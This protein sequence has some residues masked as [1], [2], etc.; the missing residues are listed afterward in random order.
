[1]NVFLL[2]DLEGIPDVLS[3]NAVSRSGST[4]Q[5]A[6]HSLT[7]CV[8][9]AAAWCREAGA[10]R[11][12]FLDGHGGGGNIIHDQ[13]DTFAEQV[14][15]SE[16]QHLLKEGKIDCQIELGAHARAGTIGG[17]L[18]HT[19]NSSQWFSYRING[20]EYSE[21][22]IHAVI[23]GRYHV[24]VVCCIGDEAACQQ[25]K[26]YIPNIVTA[27]VKRALCRNEALA[28]PDAE[29]RIHE[30]VAK[31]LAE[32]RHIE[33]MQLPMPAAIE[34][35]F[36]R[37]DM[38]EAALKNCSA[39]VQRTDARTLQKTITHLERYEDLKFG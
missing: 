2:T 26:E 18:D 14:D 15:I 8:N 20:R 29:A 21:L 22:A 4:Y 30:A 23:C 12:Y 32:Y 17:F 31:A 27:P 7:K 9:Q 19:V 10:E 3:I 39:L 25:A 24:P 5:N 38:C 33:P 36:Y 35:T 1:M 11:V 28:Y 6:C 16:W 34:L 37:T 13:L